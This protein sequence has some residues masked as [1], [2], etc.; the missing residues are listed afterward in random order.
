MYYLFKGIKI[1]KQCLLFTAFLACQKSFSVLFPMPFNFVYMWFTKTFNFAA[2]LSPPVEF[3][4]HPTGYYINHKTNCKYTYCHKNR[5]Y[6][7]KHSSSPSTS[8]RL[9]HG[10]GIL[11]Y[12]I[13]WHKY[14]HL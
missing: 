11:F 2:V 5:F 10:L 14:L 7:L 6:N 12:Q 4:D 9:L 1:N 13:G 8:S 3:V